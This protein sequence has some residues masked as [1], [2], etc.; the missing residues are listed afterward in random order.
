[1]KEIIRPQVALLIDFENLV[2]G[3]SDIHGEAFVEEL[4]PELLLKLAEEYG[5]IVL[6]Q[7]YADWRRREFNQFQMELYRLGIELIS[8]FGKGLKNAVDVK[9]A[10]DATEAICILPKIETFIIVSGDRDFI[11]LLKTLR[12]HGKRVIGV[13]PAKSASDDFAALCDRFLRYGAL[14]SIYSPQP[15]NI[16][17]IEPRAGNL[18]DVKNA[19]KEILA[20]RRNG[21]KGSQIKPLLRRKLSLTFDESE[22][23]YSRLSDLLFGL[24]DTVQVE[25]DPAGSDIVV[26]PAHKN[27]KAL[28]S[29]SRQDVAFPKD[30]VLATSK[31][32][33]YRFESDMGKRR[34]IINAFY[35]VLSREEPFKLGKVYDSIIEDYEHL[36]L[37]VSILSKYYSI[38]WQ[39]KIFT[40]DPDQQE[41]L[42]R[43][44]LTRLMPEVA[45][46]D[47]LVRVY[48][49][50][51]TYKL[52]EAARQA[53]K[54][55]EVAF[56]RDLLGLEDSVDNVT[57][58]QQLI[59]HAASI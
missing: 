9:M 1:M 27:G 32:Y 19:L 12:K 22:Y 53:N 36:Q 43:E 44:R 33:S 46:A 5:Q 40:V 23:G 38:F 20:S 26:F 47:D 55:V 8:V 56:L 51:I 34:A 13:S 2:L 17:S 52:A 30:N 41:L 3:L 10:V 14:A 42:G 11:H 50:A 29:A 59:D 18:E 16:A 45:D 7:S 21:I 58:C 28:P 24:S 4:E 37:T 57:Y 31:I 54:A 15:T 48:E 39:S 49:Q 25:V 35:E 6:A